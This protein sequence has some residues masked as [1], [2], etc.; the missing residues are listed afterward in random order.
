MIRR[1]IIRP[2]A[3]AEMSE[4]CDWYEERLPGL[5]ASFLLC[6][7][8]VFQGIVRGTRS[9]GHASIAKRDVL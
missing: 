3:E 7:D 6:V 2:E 5:G 1:L 9:V 4:A 8:A